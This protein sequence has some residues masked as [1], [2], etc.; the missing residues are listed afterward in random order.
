MPTTRILII[1]PA[2]DLER[3]L[4]FALE[5]ELYAVT[6]RAS[7]GALVMPDQYDCTIIDHHALG[8][9]QAE[10]RLFAEAFDPV[11]LLANGP[12]PLS[13]NTFRTITKPHLG[14]A[15]TAAVRDALSASHH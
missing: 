13:A 9:D 2:G 8:D 12:H 7:I 14:P 15:V 10:A 11:I 6:W 4:R 5:A 1:A 3:S